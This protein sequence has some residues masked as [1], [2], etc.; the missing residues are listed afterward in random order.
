LPKTKGKP[1]QADLLAQ[2]VCNSR[3]PL[4]KGDLDRSL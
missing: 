2:G 4:T 3:K 1:A